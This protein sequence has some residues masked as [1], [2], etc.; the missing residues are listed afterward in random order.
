MRK[1]LWVI[2]FLIILPFSAIAADSNEVLT[3]KRDVAQ[4]RVIR[5]QTEIELMRIQYG[6]AQEMLK[7]TQKDLETLNAALRPA[8]EKEKKQ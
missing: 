8:D 2:L 3:L 1:I 5:L 6:K 4:E 7:A